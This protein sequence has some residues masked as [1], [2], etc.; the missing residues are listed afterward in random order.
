MIKRFY[1]MIMNRLFCEM[2]KAHHVYLESKYKN[3]KNVTLGTNVKFP[4]IKNGPPSCGKIFIGNN[5][6]ICGTINM[7][8][9]NKEAEL[10]IGNDCYIGDSSR[11]WCA[12][13]ITIG[14]RV[15]VAHNVNIFDTATHP[16]EKIARYEHE[17]IV[18]ISGMPIDL[19]QQISEAPVI[20]H[21]DV[22]IGCNSIILKGVEIGEGSIIGAGSVVT[23]NVP[24]NTMVAGNPAKI[25]KQLSEEYK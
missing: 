25:V 17:V 5:S 23:K 14:D 19:H 3:A 11:I 22:W 21:D 13:S 7:F 1:I 24:P 9:H 2:Q 10:R 8:P 20:I 15:L 6:W 18:K 16:I 12:K 4:Y